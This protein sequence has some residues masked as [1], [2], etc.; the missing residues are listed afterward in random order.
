VRWQHRGAQ[1]SFASAELRWQTLTRKPGELPHAITGQSAASVREAARRVERD[2]KTVRGDVTTLVAAGLLHRV[3][4]GASFP[5]D[6]VNV[7]FML[8]KEV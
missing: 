1:I 5:F 2:V 6:A 4:D 8:T 3:E 7:D